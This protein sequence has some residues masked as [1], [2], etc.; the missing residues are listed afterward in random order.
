MP[1]TL[2]SETLVGVAGRLE[3]MGTGVGV[4]SLGSFSGRIAG[5]YG[6]AAKR[7]GFHSAAKKA[8][9]RTE[10][11]VSSSKKESM[12]CNKWNN[13]DKKREAKGEQKEVRE[14]N[15]ER[16]RMEGARKEK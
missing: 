1:V 6:P 15:R 12:S 9:W 8:N 3:K 10:V 13:G 4:A 5:A 14:R 2:Q 16:E 7:T 11:V